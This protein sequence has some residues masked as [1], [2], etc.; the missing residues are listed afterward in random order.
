MK[1]LYVFLL[2]LCSTMIAAAQVPQLGKEP[3]YFIDSVRVDKNGLANID[4]NDVAMV[5]VLK[6]KSAVAHFGDAGKDGVVLIET[7]AF[8]R[9]RYTKYLAS[10]SVEY[11]K[12]I[13]NGDTDIKYVINGEV[14]KKDFVDALDNI[15]DSTFINIKVIDKV[16]LAKDYNVTDKPYGAV[17]TMKMRKQ[18][19]NTEAKNEQKT[20]E[21]LMLDWPDSEGWKVG[22][23]QENEKI[24]VIDLVRGKETVKKWTELGNMTSMKGIK[25]IPVDSAMNLM[26]DQANKNPQK[27]NLLLLKR[28]SRQRTRGSFSL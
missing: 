16:S 20:G 21:S 2:T 8:V 22:D 24:R 23:D 19:Q 26:F 13:A 25:N 12:L 9:K 3:M 28:T 14:Q 5:T 10:R 18:A 15:A 4:A 11:S 17:I 1:Y 7:K 27:L 6:Q